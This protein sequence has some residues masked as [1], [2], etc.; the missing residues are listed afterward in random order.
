MGPSAAPAERRRRR[1]GDD[2]LL[3]RL[4]DGVVV[5]PDDLDGRVVGFRARALEDDTRHRHRR[6][7]LVLAADVRR[8][9]AAGAL[10]GHGGE[11]VA[12]EDDHFATAN[13]KIW[14]YTNGSSLARNC[15]RVFTF[16]S[17]RNCRGNRRR[18]KTTETEGNG[19]QE[20]HK[21]R[22]ATSALQEKQ[23]SKAQEGPTQTL[24]NVFFTV[25]TDSEL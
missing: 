23:V 10:V 12:V 21:R 2:L 15:G 24:N 22:Q 11:V 9:H 20:E 7:G 5:I 19:S 18:E 6:E 17:K 3:L 4:A 8:V 1:T 14:C 25:H 13:Q 16:S